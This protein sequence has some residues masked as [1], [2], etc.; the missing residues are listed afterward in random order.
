M[1]C[2]EHLASSEEDCELYLVAFFKEFA[3]V[4]ELD[5]EVVPFSFRAQPYLLKGHSV[6]VVFSVCGTQLSF[7]LIEPLA[8]IHYSANRRAAGGRDFDKVQS[9]IASFGNC[10]ESGYESYLIV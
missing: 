3:G 7:L 1:L 2:V 5:I 10:L 4:I 8:I 6:M 9:D